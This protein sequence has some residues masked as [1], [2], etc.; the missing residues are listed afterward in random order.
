MKM[1]AISQYDFLLLPVRLERTIGFFFFFF[2]FLRENNSRKTPTL[3][4]VQNGQQG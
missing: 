4:T 2:L 3:L 1:K